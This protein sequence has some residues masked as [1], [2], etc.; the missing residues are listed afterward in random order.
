MNFPV[1]PRDKEA[2]HALENCKFKTHHELRKQNK[3]KSKFKAMLIVFCFFMLRVL[4]CS[5]F[6][7]IQMKR[8]VDAKGEYIKGETI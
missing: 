8:C 5:F 6:M 1:R 4:S 2:V 3:A 7:K